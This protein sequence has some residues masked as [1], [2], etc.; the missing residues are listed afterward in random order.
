MTQGNVIQKID[1]KPMETS[2]LVQELVGKHKPGD[3]LNLL[4]M[5]NTV[6]T[7]VTVK[8]GDYPVSTTGK[9]P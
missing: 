2:K 4:V 7:A 6:L 5:R 1:G 8:I 3:S 9:Q